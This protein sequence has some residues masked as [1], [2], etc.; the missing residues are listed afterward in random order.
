MPGYEYINKQEKKALMKLFDEGG[1]L[2]AHGFDAMRKKYHVREFEQQMNNFFNSNSTLCVSSGTAA[3]KCALVGLGV[4]RGD[5]VITQSF[6]F[7][8]TVEAIY[9]L[10]A[11]PIIIGIDNTLNMCP[12]QLSE[13]IGPKTKAIIP[14]H[15]L[16]V[17]AKMKEIIAIGK[18]NKI[19]IIEDACEAVGAKYDGRFVGTL[20][21]YG[22]FSFDFG[23][24]ITTGE[25]GAILSKNKRLDKKVRE[26]H[27]HGHKNIKGLARGLDR[28]DSPGFNYRM[29][30]L[31]AVVGKV[32]LK[33]LN[34][35][36]RENKKRYFALESSLNEINSISLR[37][38]PQK[39]EPSFDTL[40]FEVKDNKTKQKVLN[41]LNNQKFGTKN[42]PDAIRWH[43]SYYWDYFLDKRNNKQA[44][45]TLLKLNS[46][47]AIPILLNRTITEYKILG[48]SIKNEIGC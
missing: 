31:N 46:S 43:C 29:S 16:G 10:G 38:I 39:C 34:R 48:R 12:K 20:C 5:E 47:I 40:I 19:P 11:K 9:D 28:V 7:I 41:I 44:E 21:Q 35:I 15:M 18:K 1:V 14:V 22:I 37:E 45:K 17:P 24:N 25:G 6:N 8:A 27:D 13:S 23:K 4:K 2:F 36:M 32:Q 26:H 42:L 3:I 33:K 30:E